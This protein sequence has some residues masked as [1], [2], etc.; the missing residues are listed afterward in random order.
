MYKYFK[1]DDVKYYRWLFANGRFISQ[2]DIP[3]LR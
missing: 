1:E 2:T 3:D